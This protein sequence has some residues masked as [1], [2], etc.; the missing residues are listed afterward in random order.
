M[1]IARDLLDFDLTKFLVIL[2]RH[3]MLQGI[4]ILMLYCISLCYT[5]YSACL[6]Y[7]LYLYFYD[8]HFLHMQVIHLTSLIITTSLLNNIKL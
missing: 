6:W 4:F 2:V 5:V 1:F 7:Q 8:V 3:H